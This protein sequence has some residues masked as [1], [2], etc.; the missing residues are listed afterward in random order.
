MKMNESEWIEGKFAVAWI[1]RVLCLFYKIIEF[2]ILVTGRFFGVFVLDKHRRKGKKAKVPLYERGM[3]SFSLLQCWTLLIAVMVVV[4][5]Y[6]AEFEEPFY[7]RKLVFVNKCPSSMSQ[8]CR[9]TWERYKII[10]GYDWSK[11]RNY[12]NLSSSFDRRLFFIKILV[13][14]QNPSIAQEQ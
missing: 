4:S 9:L 13:L 8:K 6:T 7:R 14:L 2:T 1:L 3:H 10:I 5:S 12:H 11:V